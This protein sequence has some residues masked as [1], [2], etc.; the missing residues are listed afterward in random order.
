MTR[1]SQTVQSVTRALE[2]LEIISTE[3]EI[4]IR[5]L[6]RRAGLSRG[7]VQRLISTLM[8]RGYLTQ[9]LSN[10]KYHLSLKLFQLGN[11]SL[12]Q[13]ELRSVARP[14]LED[15]QKR[16]QETIL[17]GTLDGTEVV[18]IDKLEVKQ[19]IQLTSTVGSRVPAHCTAT[20][21]AILAFLPAQECE[22]ILLASK[23]TSYTPRTLTHIAELT[24]EFAE[25]RIRG[26]SIDNE[27]R[28]PGMFSVG[29]PVWDYSGK[30]VG[31]VGIPGFV[32]RVPK[33]RIPLLGE[34]VVAA[35]REISMRLG[36]H[37][38]T[39]S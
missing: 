33:E 20:G 21:K 1:D 13:N 35:T 24:K 32:H 9:N 19:E 17:L 14:I 2:L 11:R 18:Y 26:Y 3:K 7:T 10:Q 27:E 16:I 8:E 5:E 25:T 29:A 38:L 6:S 39:G 4:G 22:V 23:L 36:F 34:A 28:F 31:S 12:F 37:E 30:V 15:M